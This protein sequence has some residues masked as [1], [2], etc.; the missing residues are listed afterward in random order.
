MEGNPKLE[1]K[2]F[3]LMQVRTFKKKNVV[4]Q[5]IYM[6]DFAIPISLCDEFKL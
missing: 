6:S 5:V 3:Y 4:A 2:S 1:G